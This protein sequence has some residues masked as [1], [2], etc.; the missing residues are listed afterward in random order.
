DQQGDATGPTPHNPSPARTG[1]KA[2]PRRSCTMSTERA[3]ETRSRNHGSLQLCRVPYVVYNR[4]EK[5][6]KRITTMGQDKNSEDEY[7]TG[8]GGYGR[9][10]A[11]QPP[12]SANTPGSGQQYGQQSGGQQP[13][14]GQTG[15]RQQAGDEQA[16]Y[17]TQ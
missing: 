6:E 15:E 5:P 17:G 16:C 3:S 1:T 13:S 4:L 2:F 9:Y 7:R 12:G 14:C 10:T 8:D 11:A